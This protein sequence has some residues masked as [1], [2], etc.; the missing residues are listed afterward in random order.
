MNEPP[1]VRLARNGSILNSYLKM[2]GHL[3]ALPVLPLG[4]ILGFTDDDVEGFAELFDLLRP[5][6][7][8]AYLTVMPT[9]EAVREA[10]QTRHDAGMSI[11]M[12][13]RSE[14]V[15][16]FHRA[17]EAALME[18]WAKDT[19]SFSGGWTWSEKQ[20]RVTRPPDKG[21]GNRPRELFTEA[22]T[23][24][25]D[26]WHPGEGPRNP[27]ELRQQISDTLRW[28]FAFEDTDAAKGGRIY[29]TIRRTRPNGPRRR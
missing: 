13:E 10:L 22:V 28:F 19:L 3:D 17:D 4:R 7:A 25:Y 27:L 6:I 1:L 29:N 26:A 18:T 16:W 14:L 8:N 15:T 5:L 20:R 2:P 24:L 11:P 21:F 12:N 9:P 23:R